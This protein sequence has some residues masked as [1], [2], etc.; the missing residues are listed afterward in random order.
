MKLQEGLLQVEGTRKA[1]E[2]LLDLMMIGHHAYLEDVEDPFYK[3]IKSN[4]LD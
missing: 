3:S 2:D 1:Q 4:D